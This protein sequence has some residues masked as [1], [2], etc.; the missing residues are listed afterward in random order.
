[1]CRDIVAGIASRNPGKVRAVRKALDRFCEIKE[2]KIVE[3]P[4]R[5]VAQPVGSLEVVKGAFFRAYK[6]YTSIKRGMGIGVEAGLIEFYTTTG[7]IETQVAIIIYEGK[8]S[9]GLSSSFQL[10]SHIVNKMLHGLELGSL[11]EKKRS[12]KDIG[13]T[14]G[15]IG[16]VTEGDITRETL[17]Y[18]SVV[19]ALV[20]WLANFWKE[21]PGIDD[22]AEIIGASIDDFIE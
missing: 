4:K 3:P 6:S 15:Y 10:P 12:M 17:T 13:E 9:V 19:M 16:I 5:L 22:F 21:L 14:I 11:V 18:E 2:Y 1:M 7:F 8:V 20:P